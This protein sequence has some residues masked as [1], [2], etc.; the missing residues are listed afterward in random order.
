[1]WVPSPTD[2]STWQAARDRAAAHRGE[3]Y[4]IAVQMVQYSHAA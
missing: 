4:L 1:V 2:D 3:R